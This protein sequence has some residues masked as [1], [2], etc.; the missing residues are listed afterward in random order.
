VQVSPLMENIAYNVETDANNGKTVSIK[1]PFVRIGPAPP[2]AAFVGYPLYLV[3]TQPVIANASYLY[4][5]VR[6]DDNHEIKEVVPSSIVE[7]TP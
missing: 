6:F 5:L 4:L 2:V 3:D 1:D 7:V